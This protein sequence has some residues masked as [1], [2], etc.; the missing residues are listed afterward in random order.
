M[1]K[2]IVFL[3]LILRLFIGGCVSS[4]QLSA[5]L[6]T[7]HGKPEGEVIRYLG[8]PTNVYE[9]GGAKYLT[10]SASRNVTLTTPS[11]YQSTII[12][13]TI[14]T[15]QSLS[16][17][18]TRAHKNDSYVSVTI[19]CSKKQHPILT[20]SCTHLASLIIKFDGTDAKDSDLEIEFHFYDLISK[21][22]ILNNF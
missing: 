3:L 8:P 16:R 10:F 4:Q 11:T 15:N 22:S 14:Y 6:S 2:R 19:W 7:F 1:N 21:N 18:T 9:S 5:Q 17:T 13:D 20:P 12:G